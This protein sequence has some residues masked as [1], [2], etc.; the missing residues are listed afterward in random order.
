MSKSS[1]N[2]G[3]ILPELSDT[4]RSTI[5]SI[6]ENFKKLDE[7]TDVFIDSTPTS[8]F[9]E[10]NQRFWNS[11]PKVGSYLG[12]VNIR[13]GN[14]APIW[15]NKTYYNVG[16]VVVDF[17]D[18]THYYTCQIAGTSGVLEPDFKVASNSITKDLKTVDIWMKNKYYEIDDMVLP[19]I[20]NNCYY[21][22]IEEGNANNQLE[23]NW[24]TIDGETQVDGDVTWLCH[25]IISWKESG[26]SANFR[27]FGKIE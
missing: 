17:N 13:A 2:L 20:D 11:Q 15:K 4:K 6:S 19:T 14:S 25:R 22:C 9:Y 16:D 1:K 23:P 8:G 24:K 12:W 10:Y 18:N 26:T 7:V 21:I 27:P 3:L 5:I